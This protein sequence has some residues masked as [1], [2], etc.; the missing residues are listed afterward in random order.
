M[1]LLVSPAIAGLGGIFAL[2]TYMIGGLFA[3]GIIA[4]IWVRY[5]KY[6]IKREGLPKKLSQILLPVFI[7]FAYYMLVWIVFFGISGY[8]Y[9]TLTN[10]FFEPFFFMTLPYFGLTFLLGFLGLWVFLPILYSLLTL[11]MLLTILITCR[12]HIKKMVIDRMLAVCIAGT[13]CLAGISIYQFHVRSQIFFDS[14]AQVQ[15]V[16]DEV[17]MWMY[18]PFTAG[19]L[20]VEMPW[21][22][23]ITF[24][25]NFPRLDGATAAYPVFAAMSQALYVGL[26]AQTIE[27]YVTVSRTD[28]AYE[29]LINGEI[30]IFFGT[31]PSEQQI[32]A[33]QAAG[34]E[35]TMTPIAREAFVFF[36][37]RDNPVDSLT[38]EEVQ[39][40]YQRRITNWQQ[41]GGRDERILPF[42]RSE[43]SGSQTI[44]LAAVMQDKPITTPLQE[45]WIGMMGGT[46]SGVAAYRNYSSAIGYSFRYFVT[47]MRPHDDIKL[48]AINGIAPT[49]ENIRNG[50]Y[51]FTVNVYA[52]TAATTNENAKV[53]IQW[54]LSEQGQAFIEL[55][56]IVPI[57]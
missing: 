24:T 34:V 39:A 35:F 52:V 22:P 47:G 36:V 7:S 27:N 32:L 13:I 5:I 29:R 10:V 53:L 15:Q 17:D 57:K 4:E 56:G 25:E 2:F 48:L 42:Q 20:L 50:T 14:H 43:N 44:M 6:V 38:L 41:L 31:Q 46:V 37:H 19:N 26:D 18:R 8:S 49:P 12:V 28:V 3:I 40:I 11:V 51:P 55:C 16:D 33:A 30:D 45:E 54:I 23:T 21:E 9:I 1:T